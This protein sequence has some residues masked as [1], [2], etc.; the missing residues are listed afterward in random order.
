MMTAAAVEKCMGKS[1]GCMGLSYDCVEGMV[2]LDALFPATGRRVPAFFF[3]GTQE[4]H[5]LREVARR[6]G[7][8]W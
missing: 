2:V 6:M 5:H 8:G 7:L 1:Y 3:A 4:R